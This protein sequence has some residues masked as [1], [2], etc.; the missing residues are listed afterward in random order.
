MGHVTEFY[1]AVL[2]WSGDSFRRFD[3]DV[4]GY[5]VL[6]LLISFHVIEV[7]GRFILGHELD[8]SL[9]LIGILTVK[10]SLIY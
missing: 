9:S 2:F 4:G 10:I 5:V 1:Y 8:G 6:P 7:K 3:A